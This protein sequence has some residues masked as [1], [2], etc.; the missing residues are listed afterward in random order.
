[1]KPD[2]LSPSRTSTLPGVTDMELHGNN[3][4]GGRL[5]RESADTFSAVNPATGETLPTVFHKA[6][7]C[8]INAALAAAESAYAVSR[9]LPTERVAGLLDRVAEEILALGGDLIA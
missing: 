1:M 2:L 3:F 5:S 4:I 8:E 7:P 9:Q 6:L